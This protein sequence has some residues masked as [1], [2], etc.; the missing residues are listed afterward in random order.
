MNNMID[1]K[2]LFSVITICYNSETVIRKTI[3]SVLHQTYNNIEYIIIDGASTDN[4]VKIAEE[5]R[6]DFKEKG[7]IYKIY[8]EKDNGI[9]DGMNKGIKRATGELIGLINSGD[10]YEL[11]MVE[12]AVQTYIKTR[13]DVFYA[14]INLVKKNGVIITKHSKMD[15]YPTSRHW[16]HPTMVVTKKLYEELGTYKCSGIHD[17]FDFIL[18]VRRANKNVV[19]KNIVLAN[20]RTGGTSND[21][22]LKKCKKRC[23]DRY[24]CYIDNG[25]SKLYIIECVAIEFIKYFVS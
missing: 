12:T 5:Y 25:Y 19:I 24:R 2:T 9:Y 6:K 15:R 14:D 7:Y 22:T 16:N 1:N 11:Q 4:T 18:R 20:F 8:S 17:D 3:E 21:K 23:L 13:Y 10:W